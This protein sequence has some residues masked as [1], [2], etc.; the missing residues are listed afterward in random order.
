ML[1]VKF[2]L[3][4]GDSMKI[5]LPGTGASHNIPAFR[6]SC[7]VCR[8]A[9][10]SG[11]EKYKRRNSCAVVQLSDGE[12]ILIDA[13][14]QF[15]SQLEACSV[16][17]RSINHLL[18]SH[19]HEDHLLGLFYLFSL[20]KAKG[21]VVEKT[22]NVYHGKSTGEFLV[23]RFHSLSKPEKLKQLEGVFCFSQLDE[24]V[25]FS[26]GSCSI[27]PLETNHLRVKSSSPSD[28]R[29]ESF[30]Y[31]FSENGRNFYYLVD[32]AEDL[33]E[34]TLSFM[35][36]KRADCIVIDCTYGEGEPGT[37]HGDVS[38]VISLR[39]EF[40]EGRMIVSHMGHRNF[41]PDILEKLFFPSGIEVG[42]DGME[43]I[44]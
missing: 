25:P 13:P 26:I 40:P 17:D 29:E 21:A 11:I 7:T 14:P 39:N 32:A 10:D 1:Y 15:M 30:G 18:L 23:K 43:I 3:F 28:C 42:Y 34:K 8:Q 6:C 31:C 33:P 37:G 22:L 35:H 38:S 36:K 2:A 16:N 19:R 12:N 4:T 27:V 9:R 24:L 20:N 5:V 44:L 41:T